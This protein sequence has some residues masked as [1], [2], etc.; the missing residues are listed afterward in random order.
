MTVRP[1][2][3]AFASTVLC[4]GSVL[5]AQQNESLYAGVIP[6]A[7]ASYANSTVGSTPAI[8]NET[9]TDPGG[10]PSP[11][12]GTT[13]GGTAPAASFDRTQR[14]NY[15]E[16]RLPPTEDDPKDA[17]NLTVQF[18]RLPD[19]TNHVSNL[20]IDGVS[21]QLNIAIQAYKSLREQSSHVLVVRIP[22]PQGIGRRQATIAGG[23][24]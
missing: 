20:V 3:L 19:G 7:E 1:A 15:F 8:G 12:G 14:N 11:Q 10:D 4:C 9:S 6:D 2:I 16:I 21:K 5:Q 13:T 17:M 18:S 22:R 24:G 23:E